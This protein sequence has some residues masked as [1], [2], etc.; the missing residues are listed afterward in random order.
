[1][2]ICK[3]G[4]DNQFLK[5]Q[6]IMVEVSPAHPL[7]KLMN[8]LDW[9]ELEKLILPDLKKSTSKLKWWLGR[10]LKVR[11]HLGV[12]LLQQLLNETDRGMERQLRDNAVY[13]V[14]CGKTFVHNWN[15][16]DHTKIEEFRSRLSPETQCTLT[17]AIVKLAIKKG[18]ANPAHIDI[19][20][21]VQIPDMQYPATVN[22]LVKAAAVGRRV[23]KTV[24][25]FMPE[26]IKSVPEIDMKAIKGL[27]KQHYFEKSKA[28]KQKVEARKQVLAKLWGVV[29]EA[30]QPVI[31]FA[32]IMDEPFIIESLPVRDKNRIVNFIQKAPALLGELFE[33]C[34]ENTPRQSKIFSFHRNQVDCFNKNKHHKG[35]EF[36][37]QFQIGRVGGNFVYSI[38]NDSIRMPDAA[39]L[40]KMVV[41][42]INLFQAPIDSIGTDKGYYSKENEK[43]ALD[44]G[45]KAVAIQRPNRKLNDAPVNPISQEQLEALENRRA[46]IEPIIGHLKKYW[47]M[48]RSRMKSDQTTESSGYASMLGF[49]LRQMIRYLTREA[50]MVT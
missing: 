36:G 15:I 46:G 13:A 35:V 11:I 19:D 28:I 24:M 22:L 5:A 33:R 47:Q 25:K 29:S 41:Q 6:K 7:I 43:L 50:V 27:A 44:F 37:R 16:P 9:A 18:F 32:R 45:V 34:Y 42:H 23:Q 40:K 49:N 48:G 30:I 4:M 38:P 14:F 20:S 8:A 12:F 31:R 3:S 2:S 10:K 17:N 1:M 21:T 39:S 26:M